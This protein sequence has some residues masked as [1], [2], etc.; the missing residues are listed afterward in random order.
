LQNETPLKPVNL[1]FDFYSMHRIEVRTAQ[2]VFIHYPVASAGERIGA[3]LI[4]R[5]ILVVY[6]IA[7]VALFGS[8]KIGEPWLWILVIVLPWLLYFVLFE[9]F[10]NGQTPG[11]RLLNM[12]VVRL[13][14]SRASIG[15]FILRGIFGMVELYFLGG[16]IAL[17]FVAAGGK[18][19][20]LGDLVA[21]T[22][23]IKL[24]EQ[25]EVS[26][27]EVFVTADETYVPTF[28][29]VTSLTQS[30]IDLIQRALEVSRD[31]GNAKP[32]L[33]ITEKLKSQLGIQTDMPPVKFL[34]TLIK[35]YNHLNSG[36]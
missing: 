21:G 23:V 13:D 29:N 22:S 7:I 8:L 14:G 11:K 9:I 19:Q 33:A 27:K 30:E 32:M 15:D 6:A 1:E 20:R 24:A 25:R 10:M 36:S 26:S 3:N 35:D 18:G 34:Y 5:L 16:A 28:L 4:D 31:H 12:Q 2:N 17:I